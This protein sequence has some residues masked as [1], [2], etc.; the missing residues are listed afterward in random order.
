[1]TGWFWGLIAGIA[2][3]EACSI[4]D[5]MARKLVQWSARVR[6][7]DPERAEARAEELVAV[8]ADRPGQL[9]KLSTAGC[10]VFAAICAWISRNATEW[11]AGGFG[12]RLQAAYGYV[13]VAAYA[14][15]GT[16]VFSLYAALALAGAITW[17]TSGSSVLGRQVQVAG[18]TED[19]GIDTSGH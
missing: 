14:L 5:W 10:F 6:Y 19:L 9:F 11:A 16:A 2:A 4:S 18:A 17:P 3:N 7:E 1:M 8:I 12:V 15:A 13:A